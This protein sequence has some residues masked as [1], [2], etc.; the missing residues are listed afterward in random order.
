MSG[1]VQVL[2]KH[3]LIYSSFPVRYTPF[4]NRGNGDSKR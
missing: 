3:D 4:Y 1:T 2:F